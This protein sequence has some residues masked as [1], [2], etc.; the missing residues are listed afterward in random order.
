[1]DDNQN[2][3]DAEKFIFYAFRSFNGLFSK[4]DYESNLHHKGV[5]IVLVYESNSL[6]Q[7]FEFTYDYLR[8]ERIYYQLLLKLKKG[9]KE[10]TI[11]PLK[12]MTKEKE[13]TNITDCIYLYKKCLL[14]NLIEVIEG[15]ARI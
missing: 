12:I 5:Y 11:D 8:P 14:R 6:K 1:M 2:L 9:K 4:N 3:S 15:K 7:C 13:P 10:F